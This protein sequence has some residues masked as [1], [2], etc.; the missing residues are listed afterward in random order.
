MTNDIEYTFYPWG[1][2]LFKTTLDK[3]FCEELLKKGVETKIDASKDLAGHISSQKK[4]DKNDM[5]WFVE[6]C[7]NIFNT[8]LESSKEF[9]GKKIGNKLSLESLWINFMKKGDFNPP[10]T[11][12]A[13]LSFVIFLN[14]PNELLEEQK[15]YKGTDDVGPGG[16]SFHYGEVI[17]DNKF[18]IQNNI[19]PKV[20][21]FLIFPANLRHMV[22]PFKS[23]G[24]RISVSGN[25]FFI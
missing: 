14:I 17:G 23:N 25:L 5:L 9:Y 21:D 22:Y 24:E 3:L 10:H 13:D 11:H 19:K 2:Y 20:G 18:V 12:T 16:L 7:S 15:N 8:Y 6:K 4:F 1:P